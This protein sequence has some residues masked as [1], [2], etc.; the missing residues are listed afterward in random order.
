[1]KKIILWVSA[2]VTC[3]VLFACS[4]IAPKQRTSLSVPDSQ[5]AETT[6]VPLR[7]LKGGYGVYIT[8]CYQCHEQPNPATLTETQWK[9][10]VPVM[11]AHAGIKETDKEMVLAYLLAQRK[12]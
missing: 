5:M 7:T 1:M 8:Q 9:N 6:G 11:A 10:I 12:K 4:Q 2:I 3:S